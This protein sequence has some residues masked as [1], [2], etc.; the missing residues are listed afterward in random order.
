MQASSHR[1]ALLRVFPLPAVPIGASLL[2]LDSSMLE[3]IED[4]AARND[5][6]DSPKAD[7]SVYNVV[8]RIDAALVE[9]ASQATV[10]EATPAATFLELEA[11]LES[12]EDDAA[13]AEIAALE[14]SVPEMSHESLISLGDLSPESMALLQQNEEAKSLIAEST[15]TQDLPVV[16]SSN[17][18]P[19]P[20]ETPLLKEKHDAVNYLI[21]PVANSLSIKEA[22][23]T[24]GR[25][26]VTNAEGAR[27]R[28]A[29]FTDKNSNAKLIPSDL[30]MME[31]ESEA[32]AETE[33]ESEAEADSESE[34]DSETEIAE[35]TE[36]SAAGAEDMEIAETIDAPAGGDMQTAEIADFSALEVGS[37]V[38]AEAA[39]QAE[40]SN[41]EGTLGNYPGWSMA[42]LEEGAVPAVAAAAVPQVV[43][44]PPVPAHVAALA[45]A[46]IPATAVS[47]LSTV[48]KVFSAPSKSPYVRHVRLG[49]GEKRKIIGGAA[50]DGSGLR[51]IEV[52]MYGK[53]KEELLESARLK[54]QVK[55][56]AA[57][58][59]KSYEK[60]NALLARLKRCGAGGR[61]NKCLPAIMAK[62]EDWKAD[63]HE[64]V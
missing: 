17:S 26:A 5:D 45:A 19:N 37:G 10:E 24:E 42:L 2:E 11:D 9:D 62:V 27:Q 47:R 30:A 39:A 16:L 48:A 53:P 55:R 61:A 29:E 63:N 3:L 8:P 31:T 58:Q 35:T 40:L 38:S 52:H 57:N 54:A 28:F 33:S 51:R 25:A 15:P 46:Q 1:A 6:Y 64:V 59:S 14:G 56:L 44:A 41:T 43:R 4:A 7:L 20:L 23:L 50:A 18:P 13:L 49:E 34:S 36:S 12:P 22:H 60:I 21:Q 32:E